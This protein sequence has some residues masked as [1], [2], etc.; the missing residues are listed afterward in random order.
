MYDV[1][2]SGDEL[3]R[4][5]FVN[6]NPSMKGQKPGVTK[7]VNGPTKPAA[8][9][10]KNAGRGG[11]TA[12]VEDQE[13]SATATA[14]ATEV[15]TDDEVRPAVKLF[16]RGGSGKEGAL[17]GR[18]PPPKGILTPRHKKAA[19]PP[20][21]VAFDNNHRD[22]PTEEVF[23]EDLP[24]AAKTP[25]T[26]QPK[27]TVRH[28]SPKTARVKVVEEEPTEEGADQDTKKKQQEEES[29]KG[30]N[31]DGDD[32]EVCVICSKPDYTRSNQIVFC[33]NCDKGFHQKCYAIPI[34]PEDDWFC[35]DCLQENALPETLSPSATEKP[36]PKA[37]RPD[38]PN[39]EQHL[40]T[41]QRVLVDRCC[42]NRRLKLQ[43]L[44][45]AYEKTFHLI[46]QTVLAGEGNSMMVIGAR[47]CGKTTVSD[48]CLSGG[49][50]N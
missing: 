40:Q 22:K 19:R 14:T 3:E 43:G 30:S 42:G 15:E 44:D 31:D 36:I 21:S 32:D 29:E 13:A 37:E 35:R 46:E 38:I 50:Y 17:A 23:F 7:Q 34:I 27:K 25:H 18:P 4:P 41:M 45:E 10:K 20:K 28:S 48:L 26:E 24:L 2:D 5:T 47:G 16:K 1:P 12:P 6:Q 49:G 11:K 9:P 39:L 33:E 8:V